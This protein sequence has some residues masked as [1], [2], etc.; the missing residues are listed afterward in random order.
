[1]NEH[2]FLAAMLAVV[3]LEVLLLGYLAYRT[4]RVLDRVEGISAATYLEIRKTL[5]QPR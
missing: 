2:G 1:M 3:G 4:S 5:G